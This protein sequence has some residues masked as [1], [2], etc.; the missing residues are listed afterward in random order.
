[1]DKKIKILFNSFPIDSLTTILLLLQRDRGTAKLESATVGSTITV[2]KI[3]KHRSI[4]PGDHCTRELSYRSKNSRSRL[5]RSL[6]QLL[7]IKK[8]LQHNNLKQCMS[9]IFSKS[10][11]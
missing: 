11:G 6:L 9:S 2:I 1:M 8:K 10:K 4:N 3:V 5:Y 7:T